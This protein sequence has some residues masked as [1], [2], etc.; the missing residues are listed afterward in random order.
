MKI[1]VWGCRGSLASPG[2]DTVRYGGNTSSVEVRLEDGTLII[3]DA[4][5]GIRALGR[6][7]AGY[8]TATDRGGPTSN[9]APAEPIKKINLFLSH[10]HLDHVEGIGFF[11][12]LWNPDVELHV[13]GP[14]SPLRSLQD[15]IATLMSPPLFP[16]HLADVPCRPI[17]HDVPD[18]EMQ[19]GSATVYVQP[20]AHRG[21]TVGF[22]IE[23]NGRS[24]AYIPDHEPALGVDL[25]KVE[26]EWVSGFSVA[27]G[28]D[29]L[30]H[31]SQYTEDEYPNHRA[32][33][34]SSIAHT[35]TFG[36]MTKAKD[37][38]LFHH[39]PAHS[40]EQLEEHLKRATELWGGN[41][42]AP[43]LA[44]EGMEIELNGT[45]PNKPAGP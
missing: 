7:I 23:E 18:E 38:V 20:V 43:V 8:Q 25:E 21:S 15:R 9:L 29:V 39:D 14:P 19:I 30:F 4:G 10:L 13:W 3:L 28:A 12:A 33:G 35:V 2:P 36:Q 16:V 27:Q 42:G 5:T 22:R 31:D 11:S 40:D 45:K 37:L 41:N 24:F 6:H 32:W 34:H 1:R 17:Y 44:Y 26:P